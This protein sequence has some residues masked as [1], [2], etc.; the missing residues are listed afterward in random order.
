MEEKKRYII[1]VANN[2]R[3]D[4]MVVEIIF[5]NA[6]LAEVSKHEGRMEITFFDLPL[7]PLDARVFLR[8]LRDALADAE[9]LPA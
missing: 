7:A 8:A 6:L 4:S 2:L 9:T 1:Q 3:D 5:D